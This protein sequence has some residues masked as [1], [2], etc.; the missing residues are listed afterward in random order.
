MN[1]LEISNVRTTC[2]EMLCQRGYTI[3]KD[4]ESIIIG[5]RVHEGENQTILVF[6]EPL[7]KFNIEKAQQYIT[8]MGELGINH[9]IIIYSESVTPPAKKIVTENSG[10]RTI[11]LFQATELSFNI[12]KHMF[13]SHH[14]RLSNEAAIKFKRRYGTKHAILNSTKAIARFYNFTKGDVIMVI[15]KGGYVAFRIVR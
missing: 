8:S 3:A 6:A 10:D 5:E 9:A 7:P 2:I 15:R 13:A 12:T 1:Q 11:E 14:I 4:T